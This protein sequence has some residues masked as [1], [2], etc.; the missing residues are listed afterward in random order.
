MDES[1]IFYIIAAVI[2]VISRLLKKKPEQPQQ[3]PQPRQGPE[4]RPMSFEDI[5]RELSGE[6]AVAEEEPYKQ[7]PEKSRSQEVVEEIEEYPSEDYEEYD[8]E[9]KSVY[10][11][12]VSQAKD[13]KTIDQLV[14][15][16]QPREKILKEDEGTTVK[17]SSGAAQI[18]RMLK[19]KNEAKKAIILSEIIQNKYL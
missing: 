4:K 19:N 18:A 10:H 17:K 12:S 11:K 6:E 5:L 1:I 3:G 15:Y 13:L 8:D 16:N 9:A 2:Y 14:D 7:A